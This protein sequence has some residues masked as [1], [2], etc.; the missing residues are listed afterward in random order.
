VAEFANDPQVAARHRVISI[1]DPV[2][3]NLQ[4]AGNPIKMSGLPARDYREGIHAFHEKRKP[5]FTGK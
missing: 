1:A 5:V 3:G 2:I 4:V